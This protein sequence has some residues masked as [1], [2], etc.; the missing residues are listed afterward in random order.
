MLTS[1]GKKTRGPGIQGIRVGVF[2]V[3]Y[4]GLL[5]GTQ[6]K[7]RCLSMKGWQ[8]QGIREASEVDWGIS[9]GELEQSRLKIRK[10]L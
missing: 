2:M 10:K 9:R 7:E 1:S 3:S 4:H 6:D 5:A 8:L